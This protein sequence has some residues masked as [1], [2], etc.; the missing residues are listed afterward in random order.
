MTF[1]SGEH[2]HVFSNGARVDNS[3]RLVEIGNSQ[4]RMTGRT[5]FS[6]SLGVAS[7]VGGDRLGCAGGHCQAKVDGGFYGP[8]AASMGV[9]YSVGQPGGG[10]T[11]NGVAVLHRR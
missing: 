1:G 8:N 7:V 9:G 6:G 4:I 10:D 2:Y 11:I 5:T 3:G